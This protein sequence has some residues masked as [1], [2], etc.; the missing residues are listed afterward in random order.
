MRLARTARVKGE[1][2]VALLVIVLLILGGIAWLG[3]S[4]R[5]G[6][7]KDARIFATEVIKRATVNY[8]GKFLHIHLS[9]DAQIQYPTS[10]RDRILDQ[11][12]GFGVPAQPVDVQGDVT[13]TSYLFDPKGTFRAQ[14]NYPAM[15]AK[16]ELDVSRK[17]SLWQIETFNLTWNPP[18]GATPTPTPTP[19]P[20][21]SPTPDQKH[22]RK[23]S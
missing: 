14:L 6:A 18:P 3:Y 19:L 5:R 20:T 21:P 4:S 8:D 15:S 16:L 13:F 1:G 11:L 2:G 23:T 12:R 9:P 10:W 7:E 22:K 17:M